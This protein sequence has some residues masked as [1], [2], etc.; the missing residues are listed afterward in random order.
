VSPDEARDAERERWNTALAT[1][2]PEEIE[3]VRSKTLSAIHARI[4]DDDPRAASA[5]WKE[6]R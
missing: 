3:R 2:N 5:G 6:T 1:G 4:M